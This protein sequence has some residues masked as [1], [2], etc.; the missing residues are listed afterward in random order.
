MVLIHYL[1]VH[2]IWLV[3]SCYRFGWCI[4]VGNDQL[5]SF[6]SIWLHHLECQVHWLFKLVFHVEPC[7]ILFEST[8]RWDL[9]LYC[10]P[11]HMSMTNLTVGGT[12]GESNIANLWKDFCW[13][14]W[15]PRSGHE[16]IA[17][18]P[19]QLWYYSVHELRQFVR[20]LKN[21]EAVGND[22]IPSEV[23][24]FASER[25][26]TMMSTFFSGCMLTS[27]LPST[28]MHVVIIHLLK[29]KS[30]D[31]GDVNNFRPIAIA[32]AL[33][34]VLKQVLLSWLARYL[35]TADRTVNLV[36]SKHIWYKWPYLH[37][38]KQ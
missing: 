28:L 19:R 1:V 16:C 18:C 8:D 34:R 31:Q 5:T 15:Q 21:N 22:G 37:S 10:C 11:C 25:L 14:H 35:W 2:Q 4:P 12:S 24:T 13:L 38:S 3:P 30:K 26:L 27:N 6:G 9:W 29:C 20:G 33:S 23:Y 32:T 36:S 17:D 7:Q